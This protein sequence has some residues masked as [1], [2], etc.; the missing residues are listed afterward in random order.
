M[1]SL[2]LL[3]IGTDN[4]KVLIE[5]DSVFTNILSLCVVKNQEENILQ[6]IFLKKFP[7]YLYIIFVQ[8]NEINRGKNFSCD[9]L[10]YWTTQEYLILNIRLQ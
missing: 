1:K 10:F 6:K 8:F 2:N 5:K 3:V 9:N 7:K 4:L